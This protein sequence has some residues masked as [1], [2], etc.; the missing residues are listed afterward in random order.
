MYIIVIIKELTS[1]SKYEYLKNGD[2]SYN[3]NEK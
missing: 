2:L 1:P 3:R